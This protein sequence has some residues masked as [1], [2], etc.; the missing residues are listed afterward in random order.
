MKTVSPSQLSYPCAST[1]SLSPSRVFPVVSGK[2][3]TSIVDVRRRAHR[4]AAVGLATM[5]V[6]SLA[7]WVGFVRVMLTWLH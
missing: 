4:R 3:V 7:C 5:L 6:V 2:H 1:H